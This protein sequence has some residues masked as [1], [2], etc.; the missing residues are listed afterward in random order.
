M[1][2]FLPNIIRMCDDEERRKLVTRVKKKIVKGKWTGG[3]DKRGYGLVTMR[4]KKGDEEAR[5]GKRAM[6]KIYAKNP[7]PSLPDVTFKVHQIVLMAE[8]RLPSVGDECSHL[9][10]QPSC[11]DPSHLV[12][13]RGDHNRR[14]KICNREGEC[15]CL[16][17]PQCMLSAHK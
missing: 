9:C 6:K 5:A 14:R 10:N 17:T 15:V 8:G 13:E 2:R 3:K 1:E 12:W 7:V 16:L 11:I 4:T